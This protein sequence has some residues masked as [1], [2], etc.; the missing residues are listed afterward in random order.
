M[1]FSQQLKEAR[2]LVVKPLEAQQLYCAGNYVGLLQLFIPGIIPLTKLPKS[3]KEEA[4]LILLGDN[5]YTYD[6]YLQA[7][8]QNIR[9][10]VL[11]PGG[12]LKDTCF[13]DRT[14]YLKLPPYAGYVYYLLA[15]LRCLGMITPEDINRA[16]EATETEGFKRRAKDLSEQ[17]A[18]KTPIF[19]TSDRFFPIAQHWKHQCNNIG[20]HAFANKFPGAELELRGFSHTFAQYHVIIFQDQD[21]KAVMRQYLDNARSK[22]NEKDIS[23]TELSITGKSLLVRVLTALHLG[24]KTAEFLKDNLEEQS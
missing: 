6:L 1:D 11:S 20:M 9:T 12:K 8:R 16:R 17:L 19:Y 23:N 18:S 21:D 7:H 14:P 3:L 4:T 5:D 22:I 10:F 24:D 15:T 13:S 2:D